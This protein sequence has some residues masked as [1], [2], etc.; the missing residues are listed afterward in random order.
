MDKLSRY[1]ALVKQFLSN[2]AALMDSQPIPNLETVLS[3]DEERGHYM[4]LKV[5]WPKSRRIRHTILHITI[6]NG[7]IWIEEDLTEEGIATYF[8]EQGVPKDDIVLGFQPPVMRPFT[9]FAIA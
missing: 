6:R 1:Q 4:L 3:F 5:G 2:Y 9:E 7:K 8:L